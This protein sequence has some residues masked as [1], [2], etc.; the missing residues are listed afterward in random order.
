VAVDVLVESGDWPAT[1]V[2]RRLAASAVAAAAASVAD[3]IAPSAEVSLVFTDD[4]H[5]RALNRRHRGRDAATDVLS[6]PAAPQVAGKSGPMLGD[7]V[8]A[9]ETVAGEAAA[10]RL[11]LAAR[12]SHLIVHGFLHLIGYDHGN[13]GEAAVMERLETAILARLGIADPY[14][15]G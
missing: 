7:I 11:T 5:V 4:A 6:F 13:A 3:R 10:A 8:L 14:E 12:V 1:A 2:V 15:A 9:F